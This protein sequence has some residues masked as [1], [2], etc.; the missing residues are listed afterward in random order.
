MGFREYLKK[1]NEEKWS[2]DVESK[3]EP[4][5]GLFTKSAEEIASVLKA[6]SKDLQQAISRLSF[7]INRAGKNLDPE[8]K[9]VLNHAEELIRKKFQ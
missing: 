7:Y 6:N 5:E 1:I 3:W 4:P 8:R 9:K 2:A